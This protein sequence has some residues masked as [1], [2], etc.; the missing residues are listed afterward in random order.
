MLN[1]NVYLDGEIMEEKGKY[2]HPELAKLVK[3]L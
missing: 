3:E 1:P 2:V